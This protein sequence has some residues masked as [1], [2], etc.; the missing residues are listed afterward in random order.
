MMAKLTIKVE[1][2]LDLQDIRAVI[3]QILDYNNNSQSGRITVTKT[4]NLI[5][6]CS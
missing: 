2:N 5:D 6:N 4:R 3:N 1:D